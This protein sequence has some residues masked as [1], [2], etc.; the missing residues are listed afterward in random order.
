M[1]TSSE[2]LELDKGGEGGRNLQVMQDRKDG[3]RDPGSRLY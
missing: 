1:I 3:D 2:I